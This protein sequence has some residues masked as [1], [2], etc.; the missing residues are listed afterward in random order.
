MAGLLADL[1]ERGFDDPEASLRFAARCA[2]ITVSRPG[3]DPPRR[4]ELVS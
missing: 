3:A 4:A 1:L 2:A